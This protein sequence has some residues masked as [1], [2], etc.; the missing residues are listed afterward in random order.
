[1]PKLMPFLASAITAIDYYYDDAILLL[2]T[3]YYRLESPPPRSIIVWVTIRERTGI[4]CRRLH[5]L[6]SFHSRRISDI[7]SS[8]PV[9]SALV[10]VSYL[11]HSTTLRIY[12][13]VSPSVAASFAAMGSSEVKFCES[14]Q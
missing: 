9:R 1:M 11:R 14:L 2:A 8:S 10:S 12:Y 5:Q 6:R 4:E 7:T 13:K 3:C